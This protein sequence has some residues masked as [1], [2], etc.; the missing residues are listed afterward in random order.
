MGSLSELDRRSSKHLDVILLWNRLDN[1]V[2]IDVTDWDG[3]THFRV[4]VPR[5]RALDA[6]N[7]PFMYAP[8]ESRQPVP[9]SR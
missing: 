7:H 6:F 1:T 3:E 4:E 9:V 8:A 5:E 2:S